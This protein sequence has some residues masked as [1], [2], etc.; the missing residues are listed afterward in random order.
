MVGANKN[1]NLEN[2]NLESEKVLI[3]ELFSGVGY[4]NQLFSLETGIYLANISKRKLILTINHPLCH[5]GKS[6]FDYGNILEF[7]NSEYKNNLHYGFE[8]Y[9]GY[10]NISSLKDEKVVTLP[11]YNKF[12]RIV[13]V[14]KDLNQSTEHVTKINQFL[15]GREKYILDLNEPFWKNKIV[16]V[17]QSNASRCF[18]NFYT[19]RENYKLMSQIC[20]SLSQY[21]YEINKNYNS[22]NLPDKYISVHFRFG[23]LRHSSEKINSNCDGNYKKFIEKIQIV[24][25]KK[26]IPIYIMTDRKDCNFLRRFESENYTIIYT[27]DLVK[28]FESKNKLHDVFQFLIE[29]KICENSHYFIGYEGSTVSNHIQYWRYINNRQYNSYTN[30]NIMKK[31]HVN[32][33]K[34][35]NI[36]GAGI[37]WKVFFDDN[38]ILN[39]NYISTKL[40]TL[41]NDGYMHL[42]HNLMTSLKKLGLET[43][44]TLYC[45]GEKSY[46]FFKQEYSENIVNYVPYYK[47]SNLKVNEWIEYRALQSKDIQGKALWADITSYKLFV[48]NKELKEGKNIIFIDGDIVFEKNPLPKMFSI[49]NS[50]KT[51]EMLVQNDSSDNSREEMC[52][53]F[54]WMKSNANTINITD[55]EKIRENLSSFNNDQQ[56]LRRFSSKINHK[57]LDLEDFPNGKYYRDFKPSFPYII[58]F[59]YDVSKMK[60]RRM[61]MF[62]KWYIAQD[63]PEDLS[64]LIE[65]NTVSKID[66]ILNEKNIILRQGSITKSDGL[67]EFFIST[68]KQNK[69]DFNKSF[70][71]LEIGFLAGHMTETL[72]NLNPNINITCFDISLLQ[73]VNVGINYIENNYN[74]RVNFIKGDSKKTIPEYTTNHNKKFD[75]I[76]IDGGFDLDTV[77]SDIQ[78]CKKLAHESTLLYVNNVNYNSKF[79]KYWTKNPTHVWKELV[80]N[81]FVLE[82]KQK[83]IKQGVGGVFGY[84]KF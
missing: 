64:N 7:L 75:L 12:S 31:E 77:K 22:L 8:V 13:F 66:Q 26:T 45:I 55:F 46:K 62:N 24:N 5:K 28:K 19:S 60:I 23:D 63:T 79:V 65:K 38:I 17:N 84:Y 14:D 78:N 53:G 50:N 11:I 40:I 2:F 49:L 4:Y 73:S 9:Y 43:H 25:R 67:N 33:W 74:S 16:K 35:N 10:E 41:T 48:I 69:F 32:G 58:H 1:F 51:L 83:C 57:Y 59:N 29:K 68:I 21:N 82:L 44:V 42:T 30:R 61:K 54:F 56:Y 20:Y 52:T 18:Y 81:K 3:Y 6:S 47:E 80:K 70:N 27:D 15:H 36:F 39:H 71:V 37:G 76:I 72:L 34:L